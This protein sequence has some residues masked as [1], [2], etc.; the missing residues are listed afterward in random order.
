MAVFHA[1]VYGVRAKAGDIFEVSGPED[2]KDLLKHPDGKTRNDKRCSLFNG[3]EAQILVHRNED[4]E[5]CNGALLSPE[6][7]GSATATTAGPEAA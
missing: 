2:E 1:H 3:G 5:T 6:G 4:P 7:M